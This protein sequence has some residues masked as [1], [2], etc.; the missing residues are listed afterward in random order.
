MLIKIIKKLMCY[1]DSAWQTANKAT[2]N[3]LDLFYVRIY[4]ILLLGIN[5][6]NWLVAYIINKNIGQNLVILHYNINFGVNLIGDA[7]ETYILPLLGL[8]II[9]VNFILLIYIYR[10]GRFIVYLSLISAIL[11]NLFLLASL[12]SIYFI[13]F[14]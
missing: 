13:N 3:L 11:A 7:R 5:L 14:R 9:I 8:I 12:A 6:L 4:L 10:Q 2:L 1:L